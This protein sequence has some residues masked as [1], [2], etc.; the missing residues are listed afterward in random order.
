MAKEKCINCNAKPGKRKCLKK[1]GSL[2]CPV[3]CATI[4]NEECA[5]CGYYQA[6]AEFEQK[7]QEKESTSSG[8]YFG[9]PAMQK[10]IMEA[11]MDLMNS[12][13]AV[14]TAYDKDPDK[15]LS[16]SFTF[17]STEEFSEF[18]FTDEEIDM[19]IKELGEPSATEGWFHTEE[20]TDYY[21]KAVGMIMSDKK[22]REFSKTM[23]AVFLKYYR[24]NEFGKAWLLLSNANR[25]MEGDFVVPFSVMMFFR[26]ISR[27]KLGRG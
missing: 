11:S 13:A 6:S 4:R 19:I 18:A 15:F 9:S 10:S 22:F 27:W 25:I 1:D 24:K 5:E 20:G 16:D 26:G 12:Q 8:S 3:C 2:I 14:G 21:S 17:F 7:K 23:M